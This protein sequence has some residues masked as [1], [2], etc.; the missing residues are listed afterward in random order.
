[1]SPYTA[2]YSA[3]PVTFSIAPDHSLKSHLTF[4]LGST[5]SSDQKLGVSPKA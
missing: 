4:G 3:S 5:G 1:M 2:I